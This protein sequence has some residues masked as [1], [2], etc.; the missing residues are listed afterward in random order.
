MR[1]ST[2]PFEISRHCSRISSSASCQIDPSGAIV[3]S[4]MTVCAVASAAV[5]SSI[6]DINARSKEKFIGVLQKPTGT[7]LWN[8][9]EQALIR[10][11]VNV[12][13]ERARQQRLE[14]LAILLLHRDDL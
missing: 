14:L 8:H 11:L 13:C 10:L 6:D 2:S 5:R 1:S 7:L 4:L 9:V 12:D 3:P